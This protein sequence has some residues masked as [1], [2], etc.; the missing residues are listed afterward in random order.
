MSS[1]LQPTQFSL[2]MQ[3][4]MQPSREQDGSKGSQLAQLFRCEYPWKRKR[5]R[6]M[7][8]RLE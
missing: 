4:S 8:A 5:A 2:S 7:R 6:F 3:T 1:R